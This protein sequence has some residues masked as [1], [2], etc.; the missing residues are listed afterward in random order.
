M[1]IE[2]NSVFAEKYLDKRRLDSLLGF[3]SLFQLAFFPAA[4]DSLSRKFES[5]FFSDRSMIHNSLYLQ[6]FSERAK[7]FFSQQYSLSV[8][9]VS[10]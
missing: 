6:I 3:A 4:S 7:D 1:F 10:Y 2:G 5:L 9:A 8:C